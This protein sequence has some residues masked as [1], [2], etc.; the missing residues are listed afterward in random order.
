MSTA[1][2]KLVLVTAPHVVSCIED[3]LDYSTHECSST[4][5]PISSVPVCLDDLVSCDEFLATVR[6]DRRSIIAPSPSS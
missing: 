5:P 2:N 4:S 6:A 1:S 3:T